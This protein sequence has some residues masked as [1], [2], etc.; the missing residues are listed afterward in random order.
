[1]PARRKEMLCSLVRFSHV[2]LPRLDMNRLLPYLCSVLLLVGLQP[3]VAQSTA[4]G[5]VGQADGFS[6][7]LDVHDE[8][9]FVGEPDMMHTPGLL[10]VFAPS[11]DDAYDE[12]QRIQATG[13]E[14]GD[15]FGTAVAAG[16]DGLAVTAPGAGDYGTVYL[17]RPSDDTW[18]QSSQFRPMDPAEGFGRSVARGEDLVVVGADRHDEDTG[19]ALVFWKNNGV[20]DKARLA[21]YDLTEEARFGTDVAVDGGT[22]FVSAPSQGNGTIYSFTHDGDAW[23]QTA[24]ITHDDLTG[25]ARFGASFAVHNGQLIAGASRQDGG[26]GAAFVFEQNGDTWA[27]TETLTTD[28]VQRAR[29]G[30]AVAFD[31]HTAWFGAPNADSQQGALFHATYEDGA[32]SAPH[33]A[34]VEEAEGG[35][36]STLAASEHVVAAGQPGAYDGAGV[37]TILRP[38]ADRAWV[39]HQRIEGAIDA[40]LQAHTGEEAACEDGQAGAF[41]CDNIDLLSFLPLHDIGGERGTSANDVWGWTDPETG[42]EIGLVG[43][44]DGLAFVDVTDPVNPVFL[45]ELPMTEGASSSAWRDTKVHNNYS[46]TVSDNA[47]EHGMQIFDLTQLREYYDT[48]EPATFEPTVLYD[49]INSAHNVHVNE[50]TDFAYIVGSSGGGETCGGGLHM[51]DISD[52]LNPEFKGCFADERTGR[53][54]TGY[55]HDVQCVIYD[56]PDERYEGRELCFGSNETHL[57]IAD[58]TDK[59]NPE[60]ISVSS[61]PNVGYTHQGWLDEDMRYFYM[62]DELD[63]LQGLVDNTRTLIWDLQDLEDP[64]MVEEYFFDTTASTHNIYINDNLMYLSNYRAGLHLMDI[65]DRENPALIGQFDTAP[66]QEGPGFSGSWSNYPYF[67]S[68]TILVNSIGE[69]IFMLRPQQ[70]PL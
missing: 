26:N 43:R 70:D 14:V 31:G 35:L 46:Y 42:R 23:T 65:T 3:A 18:R 32:W 63:E 44:T 58:V 54:G 64:Q 50:E 39:A 9:V 7:A 22:V 28:E 21:A 48:D 11:G 57:S 51:V 10:Y 27:H 45:G 47:G 17:F 68:G 6:R 4:S 56:G 36:G 34:D 60:A 20:W 25:G 19:T 2:S 69:G 49:R 8:H 41:E 61:Y 59:D 55:S 24:A 38:D 37:A 12:H 52:P 13:G 62:N 40:G 29:F 15:G 67:E 5:T 33:R 16:S 1:M 30:T 53:S 66:Y